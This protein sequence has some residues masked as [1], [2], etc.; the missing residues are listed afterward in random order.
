MAS[1]RL[2]PQNSERKLSHEPRKSSNTDVF[3]LLGAFDLTGSALRININA[4]FFFDH[5]SVDY[6]ASP[7]CKQALRNKCK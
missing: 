4:G 7:S 1:E 5:G 2:D 6:L 3:P